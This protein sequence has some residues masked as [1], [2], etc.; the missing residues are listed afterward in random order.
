MGWFGLEGMH[1]IKELR[2]EFNQTAQDPIQPGPEQFQGW[3]SMG[4]WG[5]IFCLECEA[6]P[7]ASRRASTFFSTFSIDEQR[8]GG[9]FFPQQ[10]HPKAPAG[11]SWAD[12]A[13][14]AHHSANPRDP[15]LLFFQRTAKKSQPI[16]THPNFG[17]GDLPDKSLSLGMEGTKTK[18]KMHFKSKIRTRLLGEQYLV[19]MKIKNPSWLEKIS[20][21]FPPKTSPNP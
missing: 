1:L 16:P 8:H 3:E 5:W 12:L 7:E 10:Q 2:D 6:H 4:K 17:L 13:P 20:T 21:K 15:Q 14:C 19:W 11:V 9:F 18:G